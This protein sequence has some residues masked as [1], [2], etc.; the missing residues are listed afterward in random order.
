L[1]YLVVTEL[2]VVLEQGEEVQ[3]DEGQCLDEAEKQE[4]HKYS[5]VVESEESIVQKQE[6]VEMVGD[7]DC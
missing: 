7:Q 1:F 3:A 5:R 4:E 6:V 2:H